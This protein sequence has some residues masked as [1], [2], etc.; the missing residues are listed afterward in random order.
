MFTPNPL[1]TW[2]RAVPLSEVAYHATQENPFCVFKDLSSKAKP[3]RQERGITSMESNPYQESTPQ[4]G[5]SFHL[6]HRA[7]ADLVISMTSSCRNGLPMKCCTTPPA[8]ASRTAWSSP[9]K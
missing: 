3:G 1:T 5:S 2:A 8:C 4:H 9:E 7:V 6:P